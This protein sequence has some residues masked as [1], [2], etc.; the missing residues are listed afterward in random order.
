MPATTNIRYLIFSCLGVFLF[1]TLS[2]CATNNTQDPR[3]GF[4]WSN[5]QLEVQI[6]HNVP[7][8]LDFFDYTALKVVCNG[9]LI[10]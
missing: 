2:L 5:D 9:V 1:I 6:D 4:F 3:C 7:I 10:M 8:P